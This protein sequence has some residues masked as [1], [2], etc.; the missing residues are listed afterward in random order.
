MEDIL[1]EVGAETC[2][3]TTNSFELVILKIAEGCGMTSWSKYTEASR[4]NSKKNRVQKFNCEHS[5]SLKKSGK[6][7][8]WIWDLKKPCLVLRWIQNSLRR[9]HHFRSIQS[10]LEKMLWAHCG[11]CGSSIR[12]FRCNKIL[13]P[14]CWARR[15]NSDHSGT[16]HRRLHRCNGRTQRGSNNNGMGSCFHSWNVSR[17]GTWR[18]VQVYI[19]EFIFFSCYPL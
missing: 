19:G 14:T 7:Y 15:N 9:R 2:D 1:G 4:K 10:V 6:I 17:Y 8:N 16:D 11:I 3:T 5:N 18:R 13:K 12:K